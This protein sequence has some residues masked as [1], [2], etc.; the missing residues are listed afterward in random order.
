MWGGGAQEKSGGTSKNFRPALCA[1]I[2]PP[3]CKLPLCLDVTV[4]YPFSVGTM[5]SATF[6]AEHGVVLPIF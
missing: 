2:V 5:G 1:G 4:S 3:T 6:F